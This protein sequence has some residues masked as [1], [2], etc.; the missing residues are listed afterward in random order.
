MS[1]FPVVRP[2]TKDMMPRGGEAPAERGPEPALGPDTDDDGGRLGA[3]RALFLAHRASPSGVPA[4]IGL[5]GDRG[6]IK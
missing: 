4:T 2:A 1:S 5:R 6:K 3:V